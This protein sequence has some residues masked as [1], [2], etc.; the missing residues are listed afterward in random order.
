MFG[1][2]LRLG[3]LCTLLLSLIQGME[4]LHQCL[5]ILNVSTKQLTAGAILFEV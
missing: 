2:T 4:S 1:A 5:L 3:M